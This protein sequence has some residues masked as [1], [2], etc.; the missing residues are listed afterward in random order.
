MWGWGVISL[1][2]G[3][4]S[5]I[6]LAFIS[7]SFITFYYTDWSNIQPLKSE[8]KKLKEEEINE[9]K[10][11]DVGYHELQIIG[12]YSFFIFFFKGNW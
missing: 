12:I 2:I 6:I 3:F 5:A 11:G 10:T 8:E 9:E 1:W 4:W 7:F